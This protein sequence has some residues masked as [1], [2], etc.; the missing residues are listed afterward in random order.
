[1]SCVKGPSCHRR[2]RVLLPNFEDVPELPD[3]TLCTPQNEHG[4]LNFASGF[5]I[6]LIH[7]QVDLRS[8]AEIFAARMNG[9]GST[10]TAFV[11]L[12]S[13]RSKSPRR[14]VLHLEM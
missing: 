9:F 4:S 2:A 1:M 3:R 12:D 5:L 13:L 11:L 7:L 6:G 8:R 14:S 10:E